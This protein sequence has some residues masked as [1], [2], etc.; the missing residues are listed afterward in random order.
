LRGATVNCE[1]ELQGETT[2]IVS[3]TVVAVV[4]D[5]DRD[6]GDADDGN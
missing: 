2:L 6:D 3:V 5:D 4:D 1:H